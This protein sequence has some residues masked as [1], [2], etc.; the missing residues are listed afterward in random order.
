MSNLLWWLGRCER[1]MRSPP[2]V[3]VSISRTQ[4]LRLAPSPLRLLQSEKIGKLVRERLPKTSL[5]PRLVIA[6]DLSRNLRVCR[7]S[8]EAIRQAPMLFDWTGE[9]RLLLWP[10]L[11]HDDLPAAPYNAFRTCSWLSQ[12]N[13]WRPV[14]LRLSRSPMSISLWN[15]AP[16]LELTLRSRS[17]AIRI[18]PELSG[19]SIQCPIHP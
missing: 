19:K 2:D 16:G 15:G 1:P 13:P 7:K 12:H 4:H 9:G 17:E 5:I 14:R 8:H 11:R 18:P 10:E 6:S 3:G